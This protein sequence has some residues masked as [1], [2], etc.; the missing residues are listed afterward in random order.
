MKKGTKITLIVLG[1]LLALGIAAFIGADVIVSR[2]VKQQVDKALAMLPEGEASCGAIHVRLFSGT[3]DVNDLRFDYHG[4]HI[5][6]KDTVGPGASIAVERIEI[7]RIF[8]SMLLNKEVLI[9]DIHVIR[10]QVELWMDEEHPENC[11]PSFPKDTSD[12]P[13]PFPL[14]EAKLMHFYLKNADLALHSVRTKLDVQVD[15]CSLSLQHL[16]YDSVFH[17]CD[18]VYRFSLAHAVVVV[19]DG[20]VRLEARDLGQEDQGALHVGATRIAHTMAKKRLGNMVKEPVTWMDMKVQRVL[21]SPFNPLRKALAKDLSLESIDVIVDK[22]DVFRDTR[23][24]PKHPFPMPQQVLMELPLT[25]AIRNV[26]AQINDIHIE[27]ASTDKNLGKLDLHGIQAAVENISNRKGTTMRVK[28]SCP[29]DKGKAQA[30]MR[31]TM[32]KDCDFMIGLQAQNIALG[33]LNP[34]IRPL[35]G[36]TADCIIDSLETEYKG[37]RTQAD[38]T[39]CMQYHGLNLKVHK[40]DDIPYKIITKHANTFTSLGNTLLP[41]SN[42]TVV[43][44]RPR[45]YYTTWKRDE[46]QPFPLYLFGPCIDGIKKTFLPGLYVHQQV[47][48]KKK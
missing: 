46:W 14:K 32:N 48:S 22:M 25:F 38:G 35:V 45:A 9:H 15:S 17:Y 36:I 8:Y 5:S 13:K 34:F 18:S 4:A 23:Y 39:F 12:V 47:N 29:V 30:A 3:A 19:P 27:L 2:I 37:N 43:D 7:G 16:A 41:K 20:K 21:T 1:V 11:F 26:Q 44:I 33:F 28:G 31:M 6:R 42:P 40:E 10:P 24:P